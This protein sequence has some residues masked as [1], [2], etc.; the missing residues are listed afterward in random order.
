[1]EQKRGEKLATLKEIANMT[2]YSI[3][4]IS[5]VL[6]EDETLNVTESTRKMILDAAV[7]LD[8]AKKNS[9]AK[10]K[11]TEPVRVGI[12]EM[13]DAGKQLDDP[14]YLY[15][16]NNVEACCFEKGIETVTLQYEEEQEIY[17]GLTREK[18]HGILAIGQFSR[19]K[20]Q[21]MEQWADKIVFI[22][23]SPYEEKYTSVI[24]NYEVGIRQGIEHLAEMGHHK[25]VFVGPTLSTDSVNQQAP[26]LRR[27]LFSDYL[28]FH[29]PELVGELLDVPW[30]SN[31]ITEYVARYLH[32][33]PEPASA[34]FAFNETTAMGVLKALRALGHRVPEDF[35]VLSYNDTVLATLM[36]PQLTSISI[37]LEHMAQVAVEHLEAQMQGRMEIPVKISIP[38]GLIKRESVKRLK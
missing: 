12:V 30:R 1:M 32:G 26:E 36:Q 15:L 14:Y 8:Y 19:R 11:K 37:H 6:N 9:L 29:R 38:S 18:L 13:M 3:A 20:I 24:P 7:K 22:D 23:S 25:I 17:R 33:H 16:K 31:D 21:A 10:K 27:T 28:K 4:T 35:S 34:F 5:R 2:G